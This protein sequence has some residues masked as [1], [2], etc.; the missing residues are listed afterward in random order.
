MNCN[1]TEIGA[2]ADLSYIESLGSK[3]RNSSILV[4]HDT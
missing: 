4:N 2:N 3:V 1:N